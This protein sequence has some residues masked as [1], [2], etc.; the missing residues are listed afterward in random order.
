MGNTQF[1][2]AEWNPLDQLVN[3]YRTSLTR[4]LT[5]F[6]LHSRMSLEWEKKG[7]TPPPGELQG[8]WCIIELRGCVTAQNLSKQFSI[9][10]CCLPLRNLL[11]PKMQ[12]SERVNVSANSMCSRQTD[13][14]SLCLRLLT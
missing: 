1:R 7:Q 12:T 6:G 13:G 10:D 11:W 14:F 5:S 9:C 8:A 2:H 3:F 4:D